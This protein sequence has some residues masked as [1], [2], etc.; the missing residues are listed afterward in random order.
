MYAKVCRSIFALM[1]D[2]KERELWPRAQV[3]MAMGVGCTLWVLAVFN[4]A[5]ALGIWSWP[6]RPDGKVVAIP[7]LVVITIANYLAMRNIEL[8]TGL[9][10]SSRAIQ[11]SSRVSGLVFYAGSFL[12]FA[13]SVALL[14]KAIWHALPS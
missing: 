8:K 6:S 12:C 9:P 13:G 5:G 7:L 3:S 4:L 1:F 14:F 2:G 11:R 10:G